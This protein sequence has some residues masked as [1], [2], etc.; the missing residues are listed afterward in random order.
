VAL[1]KIRALL[2]ALLLSTAAGSQPT[3]A[4]GPALQASESR[5]K[6]AFLYKFGDY[7]EW[8]PASEAGDFSIGVLQ[9][10]ELADELD[11]LVAERKVGGRR[12]TVPPP[13]AGYP[14]SVMPVL[15]GGPPPTRAPP[16]LL[17]PLRG[18][19]TLVVTEAR[20]GLPDQSVINFVRV[21]ERMRFDVS[22][23]AAHARGLR[24]SSRLLSIARKVEQAP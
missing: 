10:E 23:P 24:V 20:G 12:V 13:P 7:V 2:A 21:D 14:R 11:S 15:G 6:A 22:L 16:A 19:A 4:Q 5:V 1:V 18:Q 8:P 3:L 9:D 17:A